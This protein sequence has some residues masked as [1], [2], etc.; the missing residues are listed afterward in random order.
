M[1]LAQNAQSSGPPVLEPSVPRW[2][3]GGTCA[4][5]APSGAMRIPGICTARDFNSMTKRTVQQTVRA[6]APRVR[7]ATDFFSNTLVLRV[8]L[9]RSRAAPGRGGRALLV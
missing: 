9:A 2:R 6:D 4:I 1:N 8:Q 5:Q 7:R 3:L